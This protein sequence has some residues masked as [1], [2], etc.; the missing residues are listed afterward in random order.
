MTELRET[1]DTVKGT[2]CNLCTTLQYCLMSNCWPPLSPLLRSLQQHARFG[3]EGGRPPSGGGS[4]FG[5]VWV[6][7]GQE[8]MAVDSA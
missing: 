2:E 4:R 5:R 6:R 1:C 7:Q 3:A 8:S